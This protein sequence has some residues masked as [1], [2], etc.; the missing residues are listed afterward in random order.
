M[1][2]RCRMRTAHLADISPLTRL[3][4]LQHL[5]LIGFGVA[6]VTPLGAMALHTLEVGLNPLSR[7]SLRAIGRI[8]RLQHLELGGGWECCGWWLLVW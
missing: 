5:N 4:R 1:P 3:T 6:D 8:S 2:S 7:G